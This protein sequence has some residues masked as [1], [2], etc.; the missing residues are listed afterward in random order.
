MDIGRPG[1]H[2]AYGRDLGS[3][4][5]SVLPAASAARWGRENPRVPPVAVLPHMLDQL[6]AIRKYFSI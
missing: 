4:V 2:A 5:V 1:P 6:P 3:G